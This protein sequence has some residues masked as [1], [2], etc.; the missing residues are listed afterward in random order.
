MIRLLLADDHQLF[1][2][3][4][5]S[6]LSHEPGIA[7]TGQ[8]LNG[9][10]VLEQVAGTSTDLVLMDVN[11]PEMD[12]IEATRQLKARFP[13]VRVLILTMHDSPEFITSLLGSGADGYILKN[14]GREEL[15]HAINQVVSGK[16]YFGKAVM[17][18]MMNSLRQPA[19]APEAAVELT[20]RETD[21]LKLI[22][23]E[24]STHEIA[25]RLFISTHTVETHRKNLHSKLNVKNAAGLVRYALKQGWLE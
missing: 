12:G 10:Q 11:M 13:E 1:L 15:L 4:L 17:A 16:Q 14:T 21:V 2:D 22:A 19:R 6:L 25:E 3:G 18:T 20:K 24:C 9:R 7:I 5:Q 23:Q 8:S